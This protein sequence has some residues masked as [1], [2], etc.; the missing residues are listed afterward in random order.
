MHRKSYILFIKTVTNAKTYQKLTGHY[1][2]HCCCLLATTI[3]FL[4]DDFERGTC[5]SCSAFSLFLHLVL[6]QLAEVGCD[7]QDYSLITCLGQNGICLI[8]IAPELI[9]FHLF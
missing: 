2:E 1:C 8:K 6:I 3:S 9:Q 5:M 7:K 4:D